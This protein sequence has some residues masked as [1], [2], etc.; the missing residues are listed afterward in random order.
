MTPKSDRSFPCF[1][2]LSEHS[3]EQDQEFEERPGS[4]YV[5]FD[6]SADLKRG[7]GNSFNGKYRRSAV[8]NSRTSVSGQNFDLLSGESILCGCG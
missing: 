2:W 6:L 4:D 7:D 1:L 5:F 8:S 3:S